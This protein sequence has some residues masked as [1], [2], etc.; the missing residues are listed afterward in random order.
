[1]P[2]YSYFYLVRCNDGSLYAGVTEDLWRRLRELNVGRDTNV[3]RPV[4]LV[5]AERYALRRSALR[6]KREIQALQSAHGTPSASI[7]QFAPPDAEGVWRR[8]GVPVAA[9]I[10]WQKPGRAPRGRRTAR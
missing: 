10:A 4:M 2:Q 7:P 1:M 3:R 8:K 6:R 9:H 5:Y